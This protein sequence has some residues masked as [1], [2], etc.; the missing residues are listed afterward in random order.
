MLK[1]SRE[2]L[3]C[4]DEKKSSRSV[5]CLST[6]RSERKIDLQCPLVSQPSLRQL[7]RERLQSLLSLVDSP[8]SSI[9]L[10]RALKNFCL[11]PERKDLSPGVQVRVAVVGGESG[12]DLG[13]ELVLPRCCLGNLRGGRDHLAQEVDFLTEEGLL[14]SLKRVQ[15]LKSVREDVEELQIGHRMSQSH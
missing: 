8:L 4:S 1:A 9:T 12:L 11:N 7:S 5:V 6:I 15:S 3:D 13:A 14:I 10:G 2:D